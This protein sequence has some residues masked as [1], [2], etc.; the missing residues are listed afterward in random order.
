MKPQDIKKAY[1]R[2]R[3]I[4]NTIPDDVLDFMKDAALEKLGDTFKM[5]VRNILVK[6]YNSGMDE[7]DINLDEQAEEIVKLVE[8]FK[9][10]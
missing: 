5:D 6:A 2:I 3:K 1:A 4:D 9:Q 7:G 10:K 8:A